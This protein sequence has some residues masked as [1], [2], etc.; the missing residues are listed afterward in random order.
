[1]FRYAI[2]LNRVRDKIGVTESGRRLTLSV[3][4]ESTRLVARLT[5]AQQALSDL[6]KN[7]NA[8]PMNAANLFAEAIF[9]A[10]QAKALIDF[11]NDDAAAV[12]EIC[13]KYFSERL[14]KLI[15]NAQKKSKR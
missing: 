4:E 13:G 3:C 14:S 10:D 5:K 12:I 2:T 8:D 7:P 1:M 9:G 15:T 11:Y 6:A